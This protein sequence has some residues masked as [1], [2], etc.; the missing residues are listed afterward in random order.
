MI[1]PAPDIEGIFGGTFDPIHVGHVEAIRQ[2]MDAIGLDSVRFL[3][4]SV[5]PHRDQPTA[6]ASQ[7]LAMTTLALAEEP[8]LSVDGLE[9]ER[10]GPSYTIDTI[11][12]LQQGNPARQ[13]ALI[14]GLDAALGLNQWYRWQTLLAMVPII[15]MHRPG[16][17][18]P[19][20]LPSW[21]QPSSD[22]DTVETGRITVVPI[23]PID[24]SASQIRQ[25][26]AAGQDPSTLLHPAVWQ[27]IQKHRLYE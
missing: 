1:V 9:L 3:P 16:W 13:F 8:A 6:S 2:V 22:P 21:W 14:V 4:T 5:P 26:I 17:S 27:Y 18:V 7:R 25:H 10:M 24:I 11:E 15:V 23:Q 20:E 12:R 19:K